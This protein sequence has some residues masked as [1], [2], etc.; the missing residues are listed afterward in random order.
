ML[1]DDTNAVKLKGTISMLEGM[2]AILQRSECSVHSVKE[3][4]I[5]TRIVMRDREEVED[6][7]EIE[8]GEFEVTIIEGAGINKDGKKKKRIKTYIGP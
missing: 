8:E 1:N 6:G 2:S 4:A 3:Y 7:I 5:Y